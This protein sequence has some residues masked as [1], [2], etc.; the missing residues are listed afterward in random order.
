V[1]HNYNP[2][3]DI[4]SNEVFQAGLKAYGFWLDEISNPE[5]IILMRGNKIVARFNSTTDA[6]HI[7]DAMIDYKEKVS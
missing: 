1:I 5:L 2:P 6:Q 7:Y 3:Q 4:M